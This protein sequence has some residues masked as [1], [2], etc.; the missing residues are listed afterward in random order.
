MFN[1][2]RLSITRRLVSS[3]ILIILA[4]VIAERLMMRFA[5]AQDRKSNALAGPGTRAIDKIPPPGV[6]PQVRTPLPGQSTTILP[7]G[8]ILTLGGIGAIGVLGTGRI[9]DRQLESKLLHARSFHS[10]TVLPD[11]KVLVLGG[12]NDAGLVSES[13]LFDPVLQSFQPIRTN[14]TPRAYHTATLLTD[15]RILVAGG[16]DANGRVMSVLELWDSRTGVNSLLPVHLALA[17]RGHRAVL[18]ADGRVRIEG[19]VVA[20]GTAATTVEIFDP[21]T[22]SITLL[23]SLPDSNADLAVTSSIPANGSHDVPPD[24]LIAIR[25]SRPLRMNLLSNATI[26]LRNEQGPVAVKVNGAEGGMLAFVRQEGQLE[27]GTTYV[28]SINGPQDANGFPLPLSEIAFSTASGPQTDP[29]ATTTGNSDDPPVPP[30]QAGPG[31][32]AISGNVRTV[33]GKYLQGVTLELNCGEEKGKRNRA[34]SDGTGR[35]LIANV[36]SGHCRLEIDGTTVRRG[37]EVYG[38]FTPGIDLDG[39]HT[40]VLPYTIWM[41]PLDTAHAIT[42]PSKLTSDLVVSNPAIPGLELHLKAGTAIND[43]DGNSVTQLTITQIPIGRPPFPLPQGVSV[44]FFFTIQPGGAYLTINGQ[45]GGAQLYYPNRNRAPAGYKMN[46]WNYDPDGKGWFI[47]GFGNVDPNRRYVIPNSGTQVY[48]FTGAMVAGPDAG[49]CGGPI[50][51]DGGD[52]IDLGTG[53]FTYQKTDFDLPDVMPLSLVRTYRQWDPHSHAFGIAMSHNLDIFLVGDTF[54]Y[55]YID[56]IQANGSKVHFRRTSPGTGFADAVYQPVG[57]PSFLG[58]RI[59]WNGT[60]WTLAF[61]NGS[62]WKFGDGFSAALPEQGALLSM[63]DRYGNTTTMDRDTST[64]R[65]LKVTS[66]SGRWISLTYD[67][68]NRVTQALD[69]SGRAFGYSYD[70]GGRLTDVTDP[71]GGHLRYEYDANNQLLT[72]HDLRGILFLTNQY[73]TLGRVVSQVLADGATYY[74]TYAIDA[75]GNI[76]QTDV[77]DPR[78]NVRRYSFDTNGYFSG[79]RLMSQTLA[80]GTSEQETTIYLRDNQSNAV[81]QVTDPMGRVTRY[82][83]DT[84]GNV[85]NVTE[86]YGTSDA[87]TTSYAYDSTFNMLISATDPLGNATTLGLDAGKARIISMT[88]PLGRQ[89]LFTYNSG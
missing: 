20:N 71:M 58:S 73:D 5:L 83:Y 32:T 61:K 57:E 66:P 82:S 6:V 8:D 69:N 76:L 67:P 24:T 74:F 80:L 31:V 17:R 46:F 70:A 41:T 86:A 23:D 81:T 47:Y 22:L 77:T 12:A 68:S 16:S 13:E 45:P 65:L 75:N 27:P 18:Q 26:T 1:M 40:N 35:F 9:A 62:T 50:G 37:S 79:G 85:L 60:G 44:P 84:Q 4:G 78:G 88:D 52:P 54:P 7:S 14:L 33:A 10:A 64:G 30:L 11:G 21:E 49:C 59:S 19:G 87:A 55:T 36:P 51:P 3:A 63:S 72:L 42:I 29:A 89:H 43:Y 34:I 2:R 48:Q 53:I 25:F 38:I 39:G 28:L 56:L 15:G